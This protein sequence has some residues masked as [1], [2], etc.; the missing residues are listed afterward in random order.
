MRIADY[1]TNDGAAISSA[2]GIVKYNDGQSA[3][4]AVGWTNGIQFGEV[5][6]AHFPVTG[7]LLYVY[8]TS[9]QI[10]SGF[11]LAGMTGGFT[12]AAIIL[13]ANGAST[14]SDIFFGPTGG[15]GSLRSLTAT[16]GGQIIYGSNYIS[17]NWAGETFKVTNAGALSINGSAGVSCPTGI[18][19][20]TFRSVNG[21]VTAC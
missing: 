8:P 2:I 20:S 4:T 6:S 11:N 1:S 16:N 7:N 9:I 10:A 13:P 17:F 15:G 14:G 18:N 3:G 12:S 21:I 5:A 19:V